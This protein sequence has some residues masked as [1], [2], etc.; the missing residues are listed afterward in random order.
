[1]RV[2]AE[3]QEKALGSYKKSLIIGSEKKFESRVFIENWWVFPGQFL[4]WGPDPLS[5]FKATLSNFFFPVAFDVITV[6]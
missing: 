5:F 6:C 4:S 3:G 2:Q 1:M